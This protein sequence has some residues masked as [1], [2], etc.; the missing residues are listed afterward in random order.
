MRKFNVNLLLASIIVL[1]GL[2]ANKANAQVNGYA[3]GYCGDTF[4]KNVGE[5][6]SD[7]LFEQSAAILLD[8]AKLEKFKGNNISSFAIGL[9]GGVEGC[10]V[11]TS[12]N[13]SIWI[14]SSLEGENLYFQRVSEI[15]L[16]EWNMIELATPYLLTG[17]PIYIGYTLTAN[18]LPIGCDGSEECDPRASWVGIDGNWISYTAGGNMAIR[19]ILTGDNLP[20]Y[21]LSLDKVTLSS[22]IKPN[23]NFAISGNITNRAMSNINSFELICSIGGKEVGKA[24]VNCDLDNRASTAFRVDGFQVEAEGQQDMVVTIGNLN[25]TQADEDL[26]NNTQ[27]VSFLSTNNCAVRKVLLEHFTTLVCSNCPEAHARLEQA[28]SGIEDQI[29]WASHHVGYFTDEYT[30]SKSGDFLEF[31]QTGTYAPASMLDRTNMGEFGAFTMETDPQTL[32][33]TA[34][35]TP[36]PVFFPDEVAYLRALMLVRVDQ[37]APVSVEIDQECTGREMTI[38]ITGKRLQPISGK[39]PVVSLFLT[40][41]GLPGGSAGVQNNT[42]RRIVNESPFGDAIEFE[43]NGTF[44]KTYTTTQESN[45]NPKAMH[46][47]AIVSNNGGD[48]YN[49]YEVYNA[50]QVDAAYDPTAIGTNELEN[51]IKVYAQDGKICVEGEYSSIN[52]YTVDGKEMKN[53]GLASG[54]YIVKV[55][56]DNEVITSKFMF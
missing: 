42:I 23:T 21:D 40:E 45:W 19:A 14:R 2:G 44:T 30:V 4:N 52:V 34:I 8:K 5:E 54:L 55:A 3:L 39:S 9:S 38:T 7:K 15:K 56:K 22:Y 29:I 49:N 26:S 36:A 27:Q 16:S 53:E 37:F 32:K 35:V 41:D 50:E 17:E 10:P 43:S 46:V 28:I 47:V 25:G 18:S 1:L 51:E 48:D 13:L 12:K 24:L 31:Y 33:Q 20:Q 11:E 6:K